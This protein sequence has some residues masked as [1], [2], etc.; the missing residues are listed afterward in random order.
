M[1]LDHKKELKHLQ[2]MIINHKLNPT[3]WLRLGECY[4]LLTETDIHSSSFKLSATKDST[5]HASAC[6]IRA[7]IVL[8]IVKNLTNAPESWKKEKFQKTLKATQQI[9][10][11]L[12]PAFV[13]KA[14]AV[15]F[16]LSTQ[17]SCL[18][19]FL[20]LYIGTLSWCL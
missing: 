5:W 19:N 6:V 13:S 17:W 1:S 2:F 10:K 7:D 14:H 16:I 11:N 18:Y 3:F 12:P 15:C 8:R 20:S 4:G 9:V